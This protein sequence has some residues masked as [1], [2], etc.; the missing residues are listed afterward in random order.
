MRPA[1][2]TTCVHTGTPPRSTR[3]DSARAHHAAENE[4]VCRVV[5]RVEWRPGAVARDPA[6]RHR[7]L[8]PPWRSIDDVR[9]AR[10]HDGPAQG[11]KVILRALLHMHW[12]IR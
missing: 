11:G 12:R 4:V 3:S 8:V 9:L 6:R 10:D 1:P 7:D 2:R 5:G